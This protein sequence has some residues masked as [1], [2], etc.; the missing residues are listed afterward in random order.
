LLFLSL[1]PFIFY[2]L[3]ILCLKK[4]GGGRL[5]LLP[6]VKKSEGG[7][8][9]LSLPGFRQGLVSILSKYTIKVIG[10][11]AFSSIYEVGSGGGTTSI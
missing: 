3:I 6:R 5:L 10:L 2:Y 4:G 7:T 11:I 1:S 9:F 8:L